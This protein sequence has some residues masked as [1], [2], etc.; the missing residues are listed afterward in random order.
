MKNYTTPLHFDEDEKQ[1]LQSLIFTH[2]GSYDSSFYTLIFQEMGK[3]SDK[4]TCEYL[5]SEFQDIKFINAVKSLHE[6]DP[7]E[8]CNNFLQI[9]YDKASYL[10]KIQG[11]ANA[12]IE[13]GVY[14]GTKNTMN[15]TKV[16]IDSNDI[17][18]SGKV[19]NSCKNDDEVHYKSCTVEQ[20]SY[21]YTF[22]L[23][24]KGT[25]IVTQ[26]INGTS[27]KAEGEWVAA[28]DYASIKHINASFG[29]VAFIKLNDNKWSENEENTPNGDYH[30]EPPLDIN[31]LRI[32]VLVT[33]VPDGYDNPM[34]VC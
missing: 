23:V 22:P 31:E 3:N 14:A 33:P 8:V 4:F 16:H 12:C 18:L 28:F 34:E 19:Q 6:Q 13:I 25:T 9:V 29:E 15:V 30:T 7:K 20:H 32:S 11:F 21:R 27:N 5:D 17:I 10:A 24:G 2:N 1:F 26:P